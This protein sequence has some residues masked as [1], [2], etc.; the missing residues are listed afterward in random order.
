LQNH[1]FRPAPSQ[2]PP[3]R[4]N[5]GTGAVAGTIAATAPLSLD[6]RGDYESWHAQ[7]YEGV[8]PSFNFTTPTPRYAASDGGIEGYTSQPMSRDPSN[9]SKSSNSNARAFRPPSVTETEPAPDLP[10]FSPRIG[11]TSYQMY[12]NMRES[13]D[14]SRRAGMPVRASPR[15]GFARAAL[16]ERVDE[17]AVGD[18]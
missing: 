7:N 8:P 9:Q 12:E 4:S 2:T 1:P 14:R 3:A 5:A 16:I 15:L 17:W 10:S 18:K 13:E 11:P 6:I